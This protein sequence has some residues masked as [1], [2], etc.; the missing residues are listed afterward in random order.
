MKKLK[1]TLANAR[2]A[3]SVK[4]HKTPRLFV[5]MT[6]LMINVAILVIAAIV[7]MIIDDSFTNFIDAFAHGSVMWLLTPNAILELEQPSTLFLAVLVLI[8]GLV[9][10]TGTIIALATNAI[11]DYFDKKRTTSGKVY[12]QNH[13]LIL[14]WNS[15]VPELVSDLLYVKSRQIKVLILAEV[16]KHVAELALR[17]ALQKKGKKDA[18][19][20]F[21]VLVKSGNPL[22]KAELLESSVDTC[23]TVI[24][25]NKEQTV[26][27]GE[28]LGQS[29]LNVIKILLSIGH[30]GLSRQIP[31]VAEIKAFESK[32]KIRTINRSVAS[33]KSYRL[34]P[35][36]FDRR[37]GQIMAQTIMQKD[38]EDVYLEMFSFRG[39]EVYTLEGVSFEECLRVHT[40]TIPLEET[41]E[42]LY[43][44]APDN[45]AK[46]LRDDRL[47][48][49]VEPLKV[50]P[51]HEKIV[52]DVYIVGDNN[53]RRFIAESLAAYERLHGSSFQS[54]YREKE[55]LDELLEELDEKNRP[56]TILL[57]SEEHED[58]NKHDA[59]V[60][61]NLLYI[62]THLKRDDVRI[63]VELLDPKNDPLIKDFNIENTIIS[64]KIISLL[65]SKLAIFPETEQFYDDLLTIEPHESGKEEESVHIED[66]GAILDASFPKR[67]ESVKAMVVTLYEA[68]GKKAIPIG[69]IFG[70]DV[71][72]FSGDLSKT[73][74]TLEA[75][76]KLVFLKLA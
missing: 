18:L 15:K 76:D 16:D 65:L 30:L 2:S 17:S 10:F 69:A 42:H 47:N 72:L 50:K 9:L 67:F 5:I 62:E 26:A 48:V 56:A 59:N 32:E 40:H 7:A 35:I 68:Y 61:D 11:K 36:C 20:H 54:S 8:T 75:A 70:E 44:L 4:T 64:N 23:D 46:N 57:L 45:A 6:M 66:A 19:K 31:I 33:L 55:K 63:I 73:P 14:N 52:R 41:Q 51:F 25:M 58:V 29:D 34:I 49:E 71:Q 1:K 3:I 38:I 74:I 27:P 13:I 21:D 60:I 24:V 28:G 12:L 37:L 53:K 43:V 22:S 39:A